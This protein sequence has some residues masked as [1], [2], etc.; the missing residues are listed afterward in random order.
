MN[1]PEPELQKLLEAGDTT[2]CMSFFKGMPEK[3]RRKLAPACLAWHKELSKNVEKPG[4]KSRISLL[5]ASQVALFATATFS[6]LKKIPL[7]STPSPEQSFEILQDRQPTWIDKWVL[8]LLENS[9]YWVRWHLIRKLILA[10]LAK[11]PDHPHYYL[12]I[13]DGLVPYYAEKLSIEDCLL[14]D[15]DLLEYEIWKLFEY[16]GGGESSLANRDRFSRTKGWR[17]TFLSLMAKGKLPRKRL[18][19]CCIQALQRDFN[20]YRAKWFFSLYDGLNPSFEEQKE[21]AS[22]YLHLLSMSAPNVV[23]WAFKKV[24]KQAE[25]SVYQAEEL[26][27]GVQPVLESRVKGTVIRALKLLLR[28]AKQ[29]P[30]EKEN[31]AVIAAPALS[32][33]ATDVQEMALDVITVTATKDNDQLV[34]T[35]TAYAEIISPSLRH[36]LDDWIGGGDGVIEIMDEDFGGEEEIYALDPVLRELYSIPA[37]LEQLCGDRSHIP[38]ATFDGTDLPRLVNVEALHSIEDLE[39]LIDI[40]AQVIEDEASVDDI[41]RAF[42]GISRLC[43]HMPQ[44]F[45]TLIGPIFKRAHK[46]IDQGLIPFVGISPGADMCGLIHAWA[47]ASAPVMRTEAGDRYEYAIVTLGD[48]HHTMFAGNMRKPIGVL[49]RRSFAIAKRVAFRNAA[50]LL[51]SPTH[52]GGWLDPLVLAERINA[53][54]DEDPDITDVVLAILRLAP[55]RRD[56][57]L[58][59]L[60]KATSEWA[61]AVRYA[62]GGDEKIGKKAALWITASRVRAPWLCDSNIANAFPEFKEDAA[63]P[64]SFEIS[65]K[66]DKFGTHL[67]I[68]SE[69]KD[70]DV[71][72]N[73]IP[74]LFHSERGNSMWELG[75][76]GGRTETSVRWTATVWP[77]ARESFFAAAA[78]HI[79][80]N[81]DWWEAQWQNKALLEPLLEAGTPLREMGL[82]LL[83]LGLAAKEPGEY[84]LATDAA[85]AAIE[86]GRLGSDNLGQMLS[87]LLPT[88]LIKPGRLYKTLRDVSSV[89]PVHTAVVKLALQQCLLGE[90]KDKPRDF[91][92]ILV[93]LKELCI[94][95][96]HGVI[97]DEHRSFLQGIKGSSKAAKAAKMILKLTP[98][99][100]SG[101]MKNIFRQVL[102]LRVDAMRMWSI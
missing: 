96:Q 56:L 18:L 24:E 71:D 58:E 69:F 10:G 89:S 2:S 101:K 49:S 17:D 84:G 74:L 70:V 95:L 64:A 65:F 93:L 53:W 81:I 50:P 60:K 102:K 99:A 79:A 92:K 44:N 12:G 37:L 57:A 9:N 86:D 47:T 88:G 91:S 6:E 73:C 41:E 45:N 43:G 68:P 40:C 78:V 34:D 82:L 13:I 67:N 48:T 94:D 21:H 54:Q 100:E 38:A 31:I 85:I 8:H 61:K 90:L 66:N 19:N 76:I 75:G 3:D 46:R 16:E 62:F 27:V 51:S 11:K 39:E 59:L 28:I 35:L 4:V 5:P 52:T 77:G 83:T 15:P 29:W 14:D 20:H 98:N 26:I 72:G 23:S 63:E 7:Y 22:T 80:S 36:R 32:H 87:K 33:E 55:E 25:K 1:F 42:D 30:N 97:E